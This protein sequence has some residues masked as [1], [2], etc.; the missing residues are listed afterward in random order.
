M[1]LLKKMREI[2]A[3]SSPDYDK[4]NSYRCLYYLNFQVYYY[5]TISL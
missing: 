5:L 2:Y 1:I 3:Q 4:W